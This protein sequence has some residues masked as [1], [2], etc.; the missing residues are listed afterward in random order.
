MKN[1]APQ[2]RTGKYETGYYEMINM[3]WKCYIGVESTRNNVYGK[4]ARMH[5]YLVHII[6]AIAAVWY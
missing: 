5:Q 3:G 6:T 4:P 2:G 1:A